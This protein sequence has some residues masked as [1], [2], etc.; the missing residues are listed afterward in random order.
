LVMQGKRRLQAAF[1]AL[2]T[3]NILFVDNALWLWYDVSVAGTDQPTKE[4]N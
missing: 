2:Q 3:V 4:Y 1:S